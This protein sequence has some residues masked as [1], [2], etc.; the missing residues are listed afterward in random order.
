MRTA[1]R[2]SFFDDSFGAF[3]PG[4]RTRA[5]CIWRHPFWACKLTWRRVQAPT[6]SPLSC[7]QSDMWPLR[8]NSGAPVMV[9]SRISRQAGPPGPCGQSCAGF[10][11][12]TRVFGVLLHRSELSIMRR[13]SRQ[14][15]LRRPWPRVAGP[16]LDVRA[17]D[18]HWR[19][20]AQ[21]PAARPAIQVQGPVAGR[22]THSHAQHGRVVGRLRPSLR[23]SH[24][25]S[26]APA[27]R[28]TRFS[29]A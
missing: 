10:G 4:S 29:L 19:S 22:P 20:T 17:E 8:L 5:G 1:V 28:L 7:P 6:K 9:V 24:P 3:G 23:G 2:S 26:G 27:S 25:C 12:T 14:P 13:S 15:S 16:T 18:R 11:E 21:A